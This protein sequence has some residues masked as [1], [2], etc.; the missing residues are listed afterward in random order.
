MVL[1]FDATP[2]QN[3]ELFFLSIKAK[4]LLT[5]LWDPNHPLN[6]KSRPKEKN[7]AAQIEPPGS[8]EGRE[9]QE[10]DSQ[11]RS[12]DRTVGHKKFNWLGRRFKPWSCNRR[13]TFSAVK[14][15]E[16]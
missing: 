5:D 3:Q 14:R 1:D 6:E 11:K 13:R 4:T 7:P 12:N 10:V 16:N 2:A 9:G 8:G 15:V